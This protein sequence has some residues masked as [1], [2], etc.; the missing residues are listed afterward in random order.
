ML[1]D[2]FS[3][4]EKYIA[5]YGPKTFFL[6]QCGTFFEV[7]GLKNK[8]GGFLNDRITT[9]SRLTGMAI[10][11][12]KT[13]KGI[14]TYKGYHVYMC[15]FSPIDRLDKWVS[16][17]N[18]EG[19]TVA[20]WVQDKKMPNVRT[21]L[22]IYS[23]GTNFD[24]NPGEITNN[25]MV[26][27][28]E[29]N[30]QTL[31]NKT[32]MIICGMASIDIFT[33]AVYT[34]EYK[35]KYFHNPTTFDEIERFYSS[36]RPNELVVIHNITDGTLDDILQFSSIRGIMIH[37][38]LYGDKEN[39]FHDQIKRCEKQT[40]QRELVKQ[41]YSITDMDQFFGSL[42]LSD[43]PLATQALCFL[44]HFVHAHNPNLIKNIKDPIFT[45]VTDRLILANHSLKQLHIINTD[46]RRDRISSVLSFIN[47][48]K[49]SMGRRKLEH[50]LL[51][52]TTNTDWLNSEY[53]IVQYVKDNY[54]DWGT[55]RQKLAQITDF[56]KFYRK[57]I[58]NK[59]APSEL[60][61]FASNLK[62]IINI[63]KQVKNSDPLKTYLNTPNLSTH[64]KSLLKTIRQKIVLSEAA[65]VST[66]HL[67]SNIFKRGQYE[68]LDRIEEEYMDSY[69]KMN[70]IRELL[71]GLVGKRDKKAVKKNIIKIHRTDKSGLFLTMTKRRSL[72]LQE[73][74]SPEYLA[75]RLN[76]LVKQRVS[77][78]FV[79]ATE[80][81]A[82]CEKQLKHQK[83]SQEITYTS[84]YDK[85]ERS[86]EF[87]LQELTY[88]K[89]PGSNVR[90][91][92]LV[93]TKLYRTIFQKHASLKE[94]LQ[95]LYNSFVQSLQ[96]YNKEIEI[97]ITY[98]ASLDF[99]IGRAHLAEKFR[100]GCPV[101]DCGAEKAYISAKQM[102][103]ILIE[104]IQKSEIYVPNDINIGDEQDGIL[105]Y[106]TNAVGKSCLIR[107]IG[108]CVVLAQA[109]FFVPCEEFVF[110][111]YT[112][113]FTRILGNDNIFKGL[114]TFAVE[115]SELGTILKHADKNSL[116]LGDEL[117]S[118]TETSSAISIFA[119]GVV[120][121]HGRGSSFIFATHFH[122]LVRLLQ[123]KECKRLIMQH[124]TVCYDREK[125]CLVY[126]RTLKSGHGDSMYGLEVCK[127]LH[128]PPD[129]LDLAHSIR[130]D[131]IPTQRGVL[132]QR[133][134]RYNA[135]KIKGNCE[136]CG[137]EGEEF[138]HLQPQ[139]D[140]DSGGYIGHFH[141]NHKANLSILCKRCHAEITRLNTKHRRVKTSKG[142]ALLV[143]Q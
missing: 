123:I 49:T 119:A 36:Y 46:G 71:A 22:G 63:D 86:F 109:G 48:C 112:A 78:G 13:H 141:K 21:E 61:T 99:V 130:R 53:A 104:H 113:L 108:I 26:L 120:Q 28:V 34:F 52:P 138:H 126:D 30:N 89:G 44:L 35:E 1:R 92:S 94:I 132:D 115:M 106:G 127:A 29:K 6:I 11:A 47:R 137:E 135:E 88:S 111:P 15:G 42:S 75:T 64:C 121:L 117:C 102:R 116:V 110:K 85:K 43:Y 62:S 77:D 93:L 90:L 118:G 40:Y 100:Y 139:Q 5:R 65:T 14:S 66:V 12:K 17:L 58:L 54:K 25:I 9:L 134:A 95:K 128:M 8:K 33:G 69:D 82:W 59:L 83:Y 55:V 57:I 68:E 79:S 81:T 24:S 76:S 84:S 10:A 19:F 122:E 20:V 98:V 60:A 51:N 72:F 80:A 7:Y 67:D 143:M 133:G 27:W 37:K 74:T 16:L 18:G 101:I 56:E 50:H 32:P 4:E 142:T 23:P 107:S 96:K 39:F 3:Q 91:D 131:R 97:I 87:N 41:F 105:L 31:L 70:A 73:H 140:A 2:Y 129:F 103:H 124:M 114:S 125:N 136:K 45:N 38:I